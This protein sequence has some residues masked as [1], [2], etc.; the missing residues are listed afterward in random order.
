MGDGKGPDAPASGVK[1]RV[2]DGGGDAYQADLAD[3]FDADG[4]EPVGLTDEDQSISGMSAL[5]GT[6]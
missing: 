4:V 2:G 3:A 5:T 6:R 1:Y